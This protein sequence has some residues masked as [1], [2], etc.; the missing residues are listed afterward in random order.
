MI[1]SDGNFLVEFA[2]N[3]LEIPQNKER[4]KTTMAEKTMN[5]VVFK[6]PHKVALEKRPVPQIKAQTDIIVK[7]IYS[8][9]CG[10]SAARQALPIC[11]HED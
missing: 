8:A 10:R 1:S 6:K 9:L 11:G 7:V 4:N 2:S 5:A 3:K